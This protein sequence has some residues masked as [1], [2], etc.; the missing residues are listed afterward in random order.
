[1]LMPVSFRLASLEDTPR[2]L[3]I[4]RPYVEETVISFEYNAPGAEEFRRRMEGIMQ[5]YPCIVAEQD[6]DII[7]YAYANRQA[8]R[9]AYD[10]SANL[11]VYLDEAQTAKGVGKRLYTGLIRLLQLQNVQNVYGL[12]VDSNKRSLAFHEHM[13]FKRIGMYNSIGYKMGEWQDVSI[14]ELHIGEHPNPPLPLLTLHDLDKLA[15]ADILSNL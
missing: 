3:Q 8:E 12:I 7:G 2:I 6:G 13:G 1:M 5:V 14:Y 11:S 15:V 10:W 4:Y 9:A